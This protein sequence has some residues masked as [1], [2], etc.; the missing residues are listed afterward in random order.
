M[1]GEHKLVIKSLILAHNHEISEKIFKS[2]PENRR[3][4]VTPELAELL[5]SP[6]VPNTVVRD[7][8]KQEQGVQMLPRDV[9]NLRK[10]VHMEAFPKSEDTEYKISDAEKDF[11]NLLIQEVQTHPCLYDPSEKDNKS[12]IEISWGEVAQ[13]VESSVAH[14][15]RKWSELKNSFCKYINPN[16]TFQRPKSFPFLEAMA[17]LQPYVSGSELSGLRIPKVNSSPVSFQPDGARRYVNSG[18]IHQPPEDSDVSWFKG[19][20]PLIKCLNKK[21]K[22]QFISETTN[23]LMNLAD[24][25]DNEE[26]EKTSTIYIFNK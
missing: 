4:N 3:A 13:A 20:L 21:R 18:L 2:Y 12:V 24:E 16:K 7:F 6:E 26:D 8:I 15:R 10:R 1:Q 14:A 23:L 17:F 5:N 22:R 25:N 9:I 11:C 19:L